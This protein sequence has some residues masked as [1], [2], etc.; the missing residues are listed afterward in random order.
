MAKFFQQ[1]FVALPFLLF[2][3]SLLYGQAATGLDRS[4]RRAL[5]RP[6]QLALELIS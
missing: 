1:S 5:P 4:C 2:F 6:I 3:V